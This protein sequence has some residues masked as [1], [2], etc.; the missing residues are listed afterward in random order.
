AILDDDS[1]SD[2]EIANSN[3]AKSRL[4]Y[5]AI[6]HSQPTV[7]NYSYREVNDVYE[8]DNV[9][10]VSG[11]DGFLRVLDAETG[12]EQSSFFPEVLIP[13]IPAMFEMRPGSL[14]YGLDSTWT[15]WRQDL[16]VDGVFDGKIDGKS[17][18]F[19]AD[20]GGFVRLYG[21]MRR[22]GRSYFFFDMTNRNRPQLL[23][24]IRG[25]DPR[26]RTDPFARLGQ[27]WSQPTL[28]KIKIDGSLAAVAIFGGGYDPDYDLDPGQNPTTWGACTDRDATDD[29]AAR[30]VMCG[31]QVYVVKAGNHKTSNAGDDIGEVVWWASNTGE[32]G[33]GY[34]QVEEMNHSI[35]M[36]IKT[37]DLNGDGLTDRLYFADMGGQVFRVHLDH[38][39]D[40]SEFTVTRLATFGREDVPGAAAADNRVFFEAPSVALMNDGRSRYVGVALVSGWREKPKDRGVE[41]EMYFIRDNLNPA[42]PWDL[43]RRPSSLAEAGEAGFIAPM[44]TIDIRDFNFAKGL[45]VSLEMEGEK[46]F[47]SPLILF[48]NVFWPSYIP[49]SDQEVSE[50]LNSCDPPP[51]RSRVSFVRVLDG[52]RELVYNNDGTIVST[53]TSDVPTINRTDSELSVPLSG[54]GVHVGGDSVSILSG[55]KAIRLSVGNQAVR[56]TKWEQRARGGDAIPENPVTR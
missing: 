23:T 45:S 3:L 53:D 27:T 7:V 49:P 50:S 41:D 30:P 35:P 36:Q 32:S 38:T 10:F 37:I 42:A 4:Y 55:S 6:V 12:E 47:G 19:S 25:G 43:L 44:E 51:Q 54:L 17:G 20:S 29:T 21:G 34:T 16:P 31:N 14:L 15:P 46:G 2:A 18:A 1:S 56:K 24:E 9:V 48:G 5:G 22:G 8:Y 26:D 33:A 40:T 11:N 52:G 13:N 28:A 39:G